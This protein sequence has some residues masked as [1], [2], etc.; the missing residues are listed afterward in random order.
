MTSTR[1][2]TTPTGV[3]AE[4]QRLVAVEA[5]DGRYAADITDERYFGMPL[6]P[7]I[8]AETRLREP[9][10]R[11][12]GYFSMEYG[13]SANTYNVLTSSRAPSPANRHKRHRALSNLRSIDYY[14]S[15]NL[16]YQFDVPIYSGGLGILAGDTLKS[17]SDLH[18]PLAAVG[19][20]WHQGYFTQSIWLDDGQMSLAEH[21]DPLNY[22]GLVP[23]QTRVELP[24]KDGTLRLRLWKYFVYSVAHDFVVP[25]ILLDANIEENPPQTRSLTSQLYRSDNPRWQILQRLILGVGGARALDALGY[26]IHRF[27]LNEGH[28][29]LAFLE[30]LKK[31]TEQDLNGLRSR[32]AYTCHTPVAAGHD[33]FPTETVAQLLPDSDAALMTRFG[34]DPEHAH[35]INL[36]QHAMNTCQFVNA[37][38]VKHGEVTRLQFPQHRERIRSITNGV[39]LPTWLSGP[40]AELLDRFQDT[41][42]PWRERPEGLREGCLKL[43]DDAGF[44]AGVWEAHQENKQRL[45]DTLRHWKIQPNVFT[46][47]W[48]R[49]I[50]GYKRPTL[51]FQDPG[52][53]VELATRV[54]PIQLLIAGK[55]HPKDTVAAGYM[56]EALSAIDALAE[57][58]DLIRSV[59][60]ENYNSYLAKLLTAGS[61]VWLN[62]PLP[63]LEA[64][65]TSGMKA[66]ANGVLQ[67]STLDG[68]VAEAVEAD[69]GWIFGW[70]H[71]GDAGGDERELRL[72]EDSSQLYDRLE[73]SLA[74]YYQTN[75]N[76]SLSADSPWV[77]KMIRAI[78]TA[79]F[80]NTHRMVAE[81]RDTVWHAA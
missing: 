69:I 16:E 74:L 35:L 47:T 51:I 37:V 40:M 19:I 8:E 79:G 67:M 7:I 25:L 57:H 77:T 26:T 2:S 27:H 75:R 45:C 9:S 11:A 23:L 42:G 4:F 80:F 64:S 39:H 54:G 48:A 33:R 36:T 14:V 22:P 24:L 29:A 15:V 5:L 21:W 60:L 34:Q 6:R 55:A 30:Q 49:R 53:L 20:L 1:Q 46:L 73:E 28:A 76:G 44:R 17:A 72:K 38:S 62:T 78:A 43:L 50:A 71:H 13:L 31:G 56:Q 32:F 41:L 52:R 3:R 81:Y 12:V 63:P 66:I 18:V 10:S 70:Q 68:W 65:G 59:M 58:K 61:D